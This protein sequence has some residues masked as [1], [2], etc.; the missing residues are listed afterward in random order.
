MH[1]GACES[2][3]TEDGELPECAVGKCPLPDLIPSASQALEIYLALI[4]RMGKL[5]GPEAVLAKYDLTLEDAEMV[6]MAASVYEEVFGIQEPETAQL[7]KALI[8]A[9]R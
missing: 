5:L 1:C 9:R 4:G 6:V 7:L 2:Q 8:G 3:Y